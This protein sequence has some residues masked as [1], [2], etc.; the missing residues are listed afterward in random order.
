MQVAIPALHIS[1]GIF[2]RLYK[3]YEEACHK[4]DVKLAAAVSSPA[5]A[6][7]TFLQ[8]AAQILE[9]RKMTEKMEELM[10][11][12][13]RYDDLAVQLTFFH[14][15]G[16]ELEGEVQA[17]Q[18]EAKKLREEANSLVNKHW[19][20][21]SIAIYRSLIFIFVIAFINLREKRYNL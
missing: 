15:Q 11:E 8:Y 9:K 4:L 6:T 20:Y 16:V 5:Q 19:K 3:L 10:N 21:C 12:A 13:E 14:E 18:L 2:D 7:D 17:I 1:L